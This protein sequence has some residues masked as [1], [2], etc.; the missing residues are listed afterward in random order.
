MIYERD[1]TISDQD[2]IIDYTSIMLITGMVLSP[3][4]ITKTSHLVLISCTII[5][6]VISGCSMF[7][8]DEK[9]TYGKNVGAYGM[10]GQGNA[11]GHGI[12]PHFGNQTG[13]RDFNR[14]GSGQGFNRTDILI[15]LEEACLGMNAGDSCGLQTPR[16]TLSGTCEESDGKLLC[17]L[18]AQ[19]PPS[20]LE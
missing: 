13:P 7:M 20:E 18:Q 14:N 1:I 10:N 11:D 17:S 4:M 16:G 6:L 19:Q 5:V 2:R 15:K 9:E 3:Y 12:G 8:Q